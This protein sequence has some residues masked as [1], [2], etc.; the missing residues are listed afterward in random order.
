MDPL[1]VAATLRTDL[2]HANNAHEI[3]REY[4][5]HLNRLN[6]KNAKIKLY[7]YIYRNMNTL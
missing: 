5:A 7:V 2:A 4:S 3:F 6:C 1:I